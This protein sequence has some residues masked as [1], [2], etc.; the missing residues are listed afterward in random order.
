[1]SRLYS[2]LAAIY[3]EMYPKLI[4]YD[5]EFEFYHAVLSKCSCTHLLEI[6]CG[7]GLL[8]QRFL[9]ANYHFCG[10]DLSEEMLAIARQ[11]L[12]QGRFIRGDMRNLPCKQTF[13]AVI[14]T[15][16]SLV[17]L[18]HNQE[19]HDTFKGIHDILKT[20]GKLIFDC[21]G[22]ETIFS[23]F[24]PTS[25]QKVE[26]VDK[27][28]TRFNKVSPNLETGW[29]FNWYATYVV[30]QAGCRQKYDDFAVLRA[31]TK[32]ELSLFLKWNGFNVLEIIEEKVIKV[33]AERK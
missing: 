22:A 28:I 8:S 17:Y 3:H 32:D 23:N 18:I 14:L 15:G 24:S 26:L 13:D 19:I 21:F 1:M 30:E 11:T 31:F 27:T 10:L 5:R 29:T 20:D 4:D 33:I 16:R 25:E 7:S 9:E 6:A 2:E 12:G